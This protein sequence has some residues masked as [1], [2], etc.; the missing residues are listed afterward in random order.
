MRLRFSGT[1]LMVIL[2]Y[3]LLMNLI[4]YIAMVIDKKRAIKNKWRIPEKTLFLLAALGGGLGGFIGMFTQR[5]KTK[6]LSFFIVYGVTTVLHLI[7]GYF[8]LKTFALNI[9]F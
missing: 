9:K 8:L 6:H 3:Y 5:H 1:A 2:G 7:F 4:L